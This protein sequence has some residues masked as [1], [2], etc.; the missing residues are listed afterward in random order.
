[1]HQATQ[2]H[3]VCKAHQV[4]LVRLV[5]VARLASVACVALQ[6]L[7]EIVVPRDGL[8][9]HLSNFHLRG[10]VFCVSKTSRSN[11]CCKSL[12]LLDRKSVV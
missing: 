5:L 8:E 12:S 6:A 1:M 3:V 10:M 4:L 7:Q 2:A 9:S 11:V